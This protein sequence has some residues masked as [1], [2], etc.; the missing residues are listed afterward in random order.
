MGTSGVY[1]L[2]KNGVDKITYSQSDSYPNGLGKN[3]V[4]FC[5]VRFDKLNDLY[6]KIIL[7]N[8][9]SKPTREQIDICI[10]N[11]WV[12]LNVSDKSYDDWYCLL[13]ELQGEPIKYLYT[14]DNLYMINN[15]DFI[16]D[17]LY[18]EYGYIINLD[19]NTLE[20]WRG[21]QQKPQDNNRYGC[22][23]LNPYVGGYYPCK[24]VL[25]IPLNEIDDI[26]GV[27][28]KMNDYE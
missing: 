17:S 11:N 23:A 10:N 9:D 12:N 14:K 27:I 28:D 13:R 15:S 26:Q 24:M 8:E 2:R 4:E 6:D 3:I 21:F 1:G 25:E 5:K 22:N 7:V 20:F 19:S 16:K 18:C